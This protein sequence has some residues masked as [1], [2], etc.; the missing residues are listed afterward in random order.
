MPVIVRD[1]AVK[2]VLTKSNL[3]VSDYSANPYTGCLH[4]CKY[5]YASFSVW[6]KISETLLAGVFRRWQ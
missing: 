3:L 4:A 5:C 6:H 1:V 2:S